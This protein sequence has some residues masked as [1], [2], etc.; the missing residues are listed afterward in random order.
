MSV[1][2]PPLPGTKQ[3]RVAQALN[4]FL[5]GD[6][7]F[8]LGKRVAGSVLAG[9]FVCCLV[10]MLTLFVVGYAHYWSIALSENLLEGNKLE[11]AAG[12]FHQ[13][14]LLALAGVGLVIYAISA[15]LFSRAKREVSR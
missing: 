9:A 14:W 6:G 7:L 3:L 5:P 15:V 11:E 10:T 4:V 13:G 1:T 12:A 8:Y 2:P